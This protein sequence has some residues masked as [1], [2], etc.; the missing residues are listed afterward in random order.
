MINCKI[1][2]KS[3]Q[4]CMQMAVHY[5]DVYGHQQSYAQ[6]AGHPAG[7]VVEL[8]AAGHV[9]QHSAHDLQSLRSAP[10]PE[11]SAIAA[12]CIY[13]YYLSVRWQFGDVLPHNDT[14]W[15]CCFDSF[16]KLLS[17]LQFVWSCEV[18]FTLITGSVKCIHGAGVT[19]EENSSI[20]HKKF[21]PAKCCG[22]N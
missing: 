9:A 21:A 17:S 8:Q 7:P 13:R 10:S 11:R 22:F 5:A 3:G 1:F 14:F 16:M 18:F 20:E 4:C 6:S 2:C 12:V 15:F 19:I